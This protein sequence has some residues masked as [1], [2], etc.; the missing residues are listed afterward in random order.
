MSHWGEDP[1]FAPTL[2][3]TPGCQNSPLKGHLWVRTRAWRSQMSTLLRA[4]RYPDVHGQKTCNLVHC[5]L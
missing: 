4:P 1:L 2:V 3:F 5:C